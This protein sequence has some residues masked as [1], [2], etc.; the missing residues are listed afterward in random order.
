MKNAAYQNLKDPWRIEEDETLE[1]SRVVRLGMVD[2]RERGYQAPITRRTALGKL[3]SRPQNW[4]SQRAVALNEEELDQLVADLLEV[5]SLTGLIEAVDED[6]KLKQRLYQLNPSVM[7]WQRGSGQPEPDLIRLARAA[8]VDPKVN[9]YFADLYQQVGLSLRGMEA[10]EHTAQVPSDKRQEREEQF[11][12]GTLAVLYC[13]PTMELGVDIADLNAVNMRNVPPTPANYAQRSGRAGRAGQPALV[14]TYCSSYSPHDQYFFRRQPRMVAGAITPPRIDL[15]NEDLLRSHL[16]AIWLAETGQDLGHSLK[17]ILDLSKSEEKLPLLDSFRHGLTSEHAK[18]RARDRCQKLLDELE[19]ELRDASWYTATWLDDV[20]ERAPDN[21]DAACN[22]WRQLYLSAQRQRD[23]QHAIVTDHS[24][25]KQT[26]DEA[27]RLRREAETQLKL[28]VDEGGGQSD[29]YSYRYF[30]SEGFLP[31]YNFPRLPLSAYLPGRHQQKGVDDFVSRARFVAIS[32]F[33]P[34]NI[35]YFEGSRFRI[36]KVILPPRDADTGALTT[37]AKVCAVCGY[38]HVGVDA[39]DELCHGCGARL[40][41]GRFFANLFRMQN[42]STKR[43]DR[44]TSDE[45]ERMRFGYD[46][47]SSYQYARDVDDRP[48]L[49][50]ATFTREGEETEVASAI[51]APTATLWRINLGWKRRKNEAELGFRL[52]LE[53]GRWSSKDPE[54]AA[55]ENGEAE[56]T[57]DKGQF[58]A[59]VPFVEDRR[60]ALIM[61]FARELNANM[62]ASLLY[63]LKHGITTRFQL[64]ESELDGEL[65]PD[66]R[67]PNRIFFY[68]AAEGGAGVLSRLAQEPQAL[69]EAAYAALEV[70][71]FDPETGKDLHRP[72]EALHDCEAACYACLLSYTNQRFHEMLDR[73]LVRDVLLELAGC[74]AKTSG[75]TETREEMR[76]RLLSRSE[77]NLE[78]RFVEFLYE[79][80][81]ALPDD[82]QQFVPDFGTRPDFFYKKGQTVVYVDGPYHEYPDRQN[83]DQETTARLEDGGYTVVRFGDPTSWDGVLRDYSWIFGEG[84]G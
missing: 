71:H 16:Q 25:S 50:R 10:R 80:G 5:L 52:N 59:V 21:F 83:R 53:N 62:M 56:T 34:R 18:R 76:D 6:S 60:N 12:E 70:C 45:E 46:L 7:R 68:E 15:A 48:I 64:E 38:G 66:H 67:H 42:V 1:T 41:G 23:L 29:F 4:A 17:D 43:V 82:S 73:Q 54:S 51:Y 9:K 61:S 27:E 31:G 74:V 84:R 72:P 40:D 44:I 49:A 8:A 26:R 2:A 22:R 13:S 28:L 30:A 57:A 47:L 33:G 81:C 3:L 77:S 32:E 79:R 37:T 63:A 69:A 75:A 19:S 78:R 20:I 24:V 14:V 65:V 11:R 36:E 58:A 55:S 35:V 39:S